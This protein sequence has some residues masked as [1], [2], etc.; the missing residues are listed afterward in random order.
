[1]G[2]TDQNPPNTQSKT[3]RKTKKYV[4]E[5][6]LN[7][8]TFNCRSLASESKMYELDQALNSIKWD[9]IGLSEVRRYGEKV[10]EREDGSIFAFRGEKKA[11]MA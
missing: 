7:I 3:N 8:C 5:K 9:I 6:A 11:I 4:K 2:N 1:M 10:I